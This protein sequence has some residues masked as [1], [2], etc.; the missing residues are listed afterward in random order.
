MNDTQQDQVLQRVESARRELDRLTERIGK[1][2]EHRHAEPGA[3]E[4]C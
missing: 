1:E 2:Q 3:T 4:R